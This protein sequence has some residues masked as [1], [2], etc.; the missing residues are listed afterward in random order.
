MKG[1]CAEKWQL[2][3]PRRCVLLLE[4]NVLPRSPGDLARRVPEV[5]G[6]WETDVRS[7]LAHHLPQPQEAALAGPGRAQHSHWERITCH[8]WGL[9]KDMLERM[10][11]ICKW[12]EDSWTPSSSSHCFAG[13]HVTEPNLRVAKRRQQWQHIEDVCPLMLSCVFVVLTCN[14]VVCVCV[15]VCT[16]TCACTQSLSHVQLFVTPMDSSP[17]G[18]SVHAIFQ[19]KILEQVVISY[20]KGSS[21][22]RDRT[23]IFCIFRTGRHILCHWATREAQSVSAHL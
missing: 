22:P 10:C 5:D 1:N 17:P 7:S 9:K 19:A 15:C 6:G 11:P 20:S 23:C 18:S 14:L 3:T 16:H 4:H 13:L 12:R 8:N 21:W 2:L